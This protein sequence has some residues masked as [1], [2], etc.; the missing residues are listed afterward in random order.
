LAKKFRN[1]CEICHLL[2]SSEDTSLVSGCDDQQIV[3]IR[4]R[5]TC[6]VGE[7]TG[8]GSQKVEIVS[9]EGVVEKPGIGRVRRRKRE[10]DH[11]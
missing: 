11:G 10:D 4:K 8:E 2:W 6:R 7:K 3:I 1:N 5:Y 9:Y